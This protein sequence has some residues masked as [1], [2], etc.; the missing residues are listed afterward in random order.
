DIWEKIAEDELYSLLR[1]MGNPDS[2]IRKYQ[3]NRVMQSAMFIIISIIVA[4]IMKNALAVLVGLGLAIFMYYSRLTS[5]RSMHSQ[6]KFE[7]E[8][9]FSRFV[10][11]LIPYLKQSDG[12][13]G[14]YSTFNKMLG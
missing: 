7:R 10:R 4:F 2:A 1:E 6:W 13:V 14:L 8:M 12:K 9:A 5:V 3:K 11:L